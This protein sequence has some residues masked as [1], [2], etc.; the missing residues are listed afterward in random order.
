MAFKTPGYFDTINCL[1]D[2]SSLTT[3][4]ASELDSLSHDSNTLSVDGSQ[5]GVFEETNEV[6]FSSLLEGHDG[7]RLESEIGLEVLS[8]LTNQTL[9]WELSDQQLSALLITSDLTKSNS[10]RSVSVGLLDSTVRWM[11]LTGSLGSEL[12]SWGLSSS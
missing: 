2:L 9:E 8:D 6:S 4:A 10:T 3:D 5:V 7:A 11:R 12:L 1:E